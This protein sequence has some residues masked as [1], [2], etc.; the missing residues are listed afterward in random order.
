MDVRVLGRGEHESR[1]TDPERAA[2]TCNG[3]R[4]RKLEG[5]EIEKQ[6]RGWPG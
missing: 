1:V 4:S 3:N 5:R 6:F 2:S